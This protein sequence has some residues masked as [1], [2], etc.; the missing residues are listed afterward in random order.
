MKP[1]SYKR[2]EHILSLS[3]LFC[4]RP[5]GLC[6]GPEVFWEVEGGLFCSTNPVSPFSLVNVS[7]IIPARS[8]RYPLPS[9][10]H[11]PVCPSVHQ[12]TFQSGRQKTLST[13]PTVSICPSNHLP[14]PPPCVILSIH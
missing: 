7:S 4:E 12:F 9:D 1:R 8:S 14:I 3:Q 2:N 6:I 11:L 10:C 5:N 13:Y